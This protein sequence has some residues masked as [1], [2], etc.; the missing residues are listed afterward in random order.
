MLLARCALVKNKAFPIGG[1]ELL[2]PGIFRVLYSNTA[3]EGVLILIL[4][5]M[6]RLLQYLKDTQ[7]E[8]KHV[9]WPTQKQTAI[10]TVLVIIVSLIVAAYL[11]ALDFLLTSGLDTVI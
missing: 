3:R 6:K 8:L 9:S 4:N 5:Y 10:F 7:A 2:T 11:G 1:C